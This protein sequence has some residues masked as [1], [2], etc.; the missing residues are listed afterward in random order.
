MCVIRVI[1]NRTKKTRNKSLAIPAAAAAIPV[2]PRI[3][4]MIATTKNIK[5]Q[6]NIG[7]SSL[8]LLHS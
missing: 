1:K 3:A 7:S 5:D 6:Y 2:K 8:K 4:A